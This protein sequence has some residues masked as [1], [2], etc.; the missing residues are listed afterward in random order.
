MGELPF[1]V[2]GCSVPSTVPFP[3]LLLT[4]LLLQHPLPEQSRLLRRRPPTAAEL[5]SAFATPDTRAQAAHACC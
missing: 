3:F 5:A 1:T 4:T 2:H